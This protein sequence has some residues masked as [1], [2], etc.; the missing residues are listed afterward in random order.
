MSLNSIKFEKV[1]FTRM[2]KKL[3][4]GLEVVE[5]N[6]NIQVMETRSLN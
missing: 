2:S 6:K 4:R 5:K 1:I 3:P